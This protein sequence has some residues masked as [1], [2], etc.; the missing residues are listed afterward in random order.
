MACLKMIFAYKF[1]RDFKLV[2][3]GK[4]CQKYEGYVKRGKNLDGLY[5]KPF[6]EFLKEE[7]NM[8]S[9]VVSPMTTQEIIKEIEKNNFVMASVSFEIRNLTNKVSFRGGHL[10]LIV[11]YDFN[12]QVLYIHNPS[13][14]NEKTQAFA[15]VNFYNF[16][17]LFAYR[18][19]V[20]Q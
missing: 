4:L 5:Y 1:K 2:E 14:I 15:K 11:G 10:V 20:I 12:K 17:K 19:I 13:G 7:F 3:L 8:P 18:G 6:V 9:K 16:N